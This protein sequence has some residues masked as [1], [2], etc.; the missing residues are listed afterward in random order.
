MWALIYTSVVGMSLHT[1]IEYRR[2][3][4]GYFVK[5]ADCVAYA[6]ERNYHPFV[7]DNMPYYACERR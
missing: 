1:P 6:V 4:Q 5:E 3:I 2:E 7:S